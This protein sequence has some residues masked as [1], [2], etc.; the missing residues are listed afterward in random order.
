MKIKLLY[1]LIW[2]STGFLGVLYYSP[3]LVG[4]AALETLLPVCSWLLC[5]LAA[6][7]IRV[8]LYLPIGVAE[9][10]QSVT[11]GVELENKSRIP[12]MQAEAKVRIKN[13]FYQSEEIMIFQ[14][15]AEGKGK[16][17]MTKELSS[18]QCGP[19]VLE[20]FDVKV[21]DFFHLFRKRLA[22]EGRE[23]LAVLPLFYSTAVL[24]EE[25]TRDFLVES[26][27]YDKKKSGDDPSEIFQIREYR[28][29]D[30]MQ[31]IHWKLSARTDDLMVKEYSLPIGSAVVFFWDME[32]D[33]D[34]GYG[35]LDEFIEAGLAISRAVLE[36]GC[37]H[38]VVWF[39]R[40]S[41]DVE[42][43]AME[44]E[45]DLYLLIERIFSS[46]PYPEPVDMETV[47]REKYRGENWKTQLLINLKKELWRD[48]NLEL[49][50]SGK[51]REVLES[52]ELLV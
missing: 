40:N 17:R 5:R 26:E 45:D 46:G 43:M 10:D 12:V 14:G 8:S 7:K 28:G 33:P 6:G 51:A 18:S 38:Y 35:Y 49:E 36:A 31:S 9:K 1:L 23:T 44:S 50:L 47:Y 30:R 41:L 2:L 16:T 20:L 25:S 29:G 24:L 37:Q 15:M 42:R 27:E 4:L 22:A 32:Y 34:I 52:R 3:A 21:Y 39:D 19:I 11:A 13:Q 48:G